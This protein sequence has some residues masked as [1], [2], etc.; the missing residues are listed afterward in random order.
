M[1]T[2]HPHRLVIQAESAETTTE[3]V[4]AAPQE[5]ALPQEV[6]GKRQLRALLHGEVRNV[7]PLAGKLYQLLAARIALRHCTHVGKYARLQGR[8]YVRNAGRIILGDR[9]RIFGTAVRC[10]LVAHAGALLEIGEQTS[11]NYGASISAHQHVRIGARCLIGTYTNILDNSYHDIVDHTKIPPSRPII[12]GDDVW[13]GGHVII[14][15]GVTIGDQAT[16]A[17]GS[18]VRSNVP[19]RS[20]VAGNPAQVIAKL[21]S[22]RARGASE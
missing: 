18:I 14:S 21:P 16:V 4:H 19:A 2:S 10:E 5:A 6:V 17:A 3:P 8:V 20:V 9:V 22:G 12:I 7:V 1:D 11:L 13:I 15:P